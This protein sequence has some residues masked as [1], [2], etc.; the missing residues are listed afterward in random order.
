MDR[1]TL[2]RALAVGVGTVLAGCSRSSVQG[3]VVSN[4]TPLTF[5]HEYAI[6]ATSSGTRIVVDV[7]IENDGRDAI[8]ADGRVPRIT[9]TFLDNSDERIHRSGRELTEPL[10]TGETTSL[11]FSLAVDVD[12]A[13]R[14]E[15][16]SEWTNE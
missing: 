4:E 13:T 6:G 1:R 16:R 9:C 11:S 15:L 14:Y 3:A 8:T 12:D 10:G 5:T 2:L 7:T